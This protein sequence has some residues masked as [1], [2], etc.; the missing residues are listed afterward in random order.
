MVSGNVIEAIVGSSSDAIVT[1]DS[2]GNVVSWNPAAERIFGYT[3][4]EMIGRPL[5]RLMP[6]R[7]RALHDAGISRVVKTGKT[8]V[9]GQV[10][11]LTGQHK[12]GHEF[13]LQLTLSTWA[14]DGD[15]FFGGIIRDMTE[16]SRMTEKL[17][18]SEQRM[19]AIMDS[20]NDAIVC[21][22]AEGNVI[23]W[24]AA[25][26]KMLGHR[27]DEMVGK[28]LTEIIP[29]KFRSLH[30]AGIKR[31]ASGG[32]RHVIGKTVQLAALHRDGYEL[33]IELSLATWETNGERFFSGFIRDVS[34]KVAL[35]DNLSQSEERM[36]SIMDTANDA[37][38]VADE[39]GDI[40][41]CNPAAQKMLGYT[42]EDW[43]GKPLTV[44]IPER[45]RAAHEAGIKRIR[46]DGD[47]HVIGSTVELQALHSDGHEIPI[48]LSLGTWTTG[49]KRFFSG[50]LRDITARKEAEAEMQR[51]NESLDE[52]NRMLESLSI[53]L[54]KYLSKQVYNSIFSGQKDVKV[55]SYR[56]KLTVF[57]SDIQGFTELTD[58]MEAETLS[59]LLN[60]YLSEMSKIAE[61]FGGTIDKFIGDGIMIFFGDPES[62]GEKEDAVACVRMALKMR[63]RI[64]DLCREWTN[65][66]ADDPLHVRI[67]VNTGFCTV[68]NFGSEERMDYTIV[69]G[70]VNATSRLETAASP[71][72]ILISHATYALVK[73]QIHCKRVGEIK[74][75]GI[76]HPIKTYEAVCTHEEYKLGAR[77][78]AEGGEGYQVS[79]D[80]TALDEEERKRARVSL[81]KALD[82]LEKGEKP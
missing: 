62:K 46:N 81:L 14:T 68:G 27:A 69:G 59:G 56:K 4:E 72:Q 18:Q 20:A 31:V 1:G 9:V 53:K 6:E 82:A 40:I 21:A 2:D 51:M 16:K 65:A 75:K 58:K 42:I 25:A 74:V 45:Y 76:A 23:L 71:D 64:H 36:R 37:M 61:E 24:N 33:P 78:I 57:F 47:R 43:V 19:R 7:F 12:E 66:G 10:L 77:T 3:A 28:S 41:L 13:P 70:Q 60:N 44:F 39:M 79:V 5:S 11:D 15:R 49:G 73:D 30:E 55:E 63:Q 17:V 26:E 32:E 52:K 22:N 29:E 35:I 54:A 38:I 50:I 34:E 8:K 80:L 48:E 67:G